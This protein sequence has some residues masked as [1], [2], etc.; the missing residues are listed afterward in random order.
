MQRY[1]N[2]FHFY[3]NYVKNYASTSY[4]GLIPLILTVCGIIFF[5]SKPIVK[6]RKKRICTVAYIGHQCV[7]FSGLQ[8]RDAYISK[9]ATRIFIAKI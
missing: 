7:F 2:C 1:L 9:F 6:T 5:I 8:I 3:L 4:Q